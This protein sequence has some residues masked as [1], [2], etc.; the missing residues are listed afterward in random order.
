M[1]RK[2]LLKCTLRVGKQRRWNKEMECVDRLEAL[3][4][5]KERESGR[6]SA[7]DGETQERI[8]GKERRNSVVKEKGTE[9]ESKKRK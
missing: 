5:R 1:R 3:Y 9:G 4:L 6:V 7:E 8:Q 2:R